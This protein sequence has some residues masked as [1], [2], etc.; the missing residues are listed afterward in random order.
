MADK[1]GEHSKDPGPSKSDDGKASETG[2]TL[3]KQ[4][5]ENIIDGL[6]KRLAGNKGGLPTDPSK[7]GN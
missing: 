6:M 7:T 3:S 4:E 5:T 1:E 2:A